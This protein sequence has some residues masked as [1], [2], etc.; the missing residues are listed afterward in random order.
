MRGSR[1][2]CQRLFLADERRREG[3]NTTIS[4]PPHGLSLA[5]RWWPNIECWLC[6]F[7]TFQGIRTSI[8]LET[9]CFCDFSMGGGG[10]GALDPLFPLCIRPWRSSIGPTL[11]IFLFPH[12]PPCL[13][14]M[15]RSVENYFILLPKLDTH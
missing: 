1:E 15:G 11:E 3:P 9:L 13:T 2:F 12:T 8:A 14:G 10:G 4:M 7:V 5:S 6:T